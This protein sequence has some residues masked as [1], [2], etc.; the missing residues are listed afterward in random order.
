MG[1]KK[2]EEEEE[3][4]P[5]KETEPDHEVGGEEEQLT[6]GNDTIT[7]FE[8]IFNCNVKANERRNTI[9]QF[10]KVLILSKNNRRDK[11]N[12]TILDFDELY[13][14]T[15]QNV[16]EVD[17]SDKPPDLKTSKGI[18]S[19]NEIVPSSV[20]NPPVNSTDEAIFKV[21]KT[22]KLHRRKIAKSSKL[23]KPFKC[24]H[25]EWRGANTA[26]VKS[27]VTRTHKK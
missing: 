8:E 21:P 10:Q 11:N 6:T 25:C 17:P 20:T 12:D 3:V 5:V 18:E 1:K 4:E 16:T 23:E 7:D 27:H 14:S 9:V 22:P 15:D 13:K 2:P 24:P 26:V 19:D